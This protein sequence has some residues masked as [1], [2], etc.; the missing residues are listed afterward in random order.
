MLP[1]T[2]TSEDAIR[3][4]DL[5]S[6]DDTYRALFEKDPAQALGRISAHAGALATDCAAAGPLA[7]KEA[8]T[9][10]RAQLLEHLSQNAVFHP[11]HCFVADQTGTAP[12]RTPKP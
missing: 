1:S 6:T 4:L 12:D 10:A 2:L 8:F 7:S 5:L 9:A 3:L 11:P